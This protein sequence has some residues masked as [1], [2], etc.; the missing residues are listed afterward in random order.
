MAEELVGIKP[1]VSIYI[2]DRNIDLNY[3]PELKTPSVIIQPR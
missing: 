2:L 3:D 1:Y